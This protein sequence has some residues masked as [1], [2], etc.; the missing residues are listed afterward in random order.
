MYYTIGQTVFGYLRDARKAAYE[1]HYEKYMRSWK[2]PIYVFNDKGRGSIN[3]VI[4][5]TVKKGTKTNEFGLN[6]N[7]R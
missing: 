3:T 4:S 7:L 6:W 5:Q 1:L 2:E